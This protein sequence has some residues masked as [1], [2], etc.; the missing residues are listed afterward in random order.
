MLL[1]PLPLLLLERPCSKA[2]GGSSKLGAHGT[3]EHAASIPML[4][5]VLV[6]KGKRQVLWRM[7][8]VGRCMMRAEHRLE[9]R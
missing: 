2:L 9:G 6:P 3:H 1:K 5:L 8:Q 7:G 4:L